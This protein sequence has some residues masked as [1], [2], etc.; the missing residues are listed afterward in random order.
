VGEKLY[1]YKSS[2][3]QLLQAMV[4]ATNAAS[5]AVQEVEDTGLILPPIPSSDDYEND[6]AVRF[7]RSMK[8][9]TPRDHDHVTTWAES[10]GIRLLT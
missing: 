4:K 3:P 1:K 7:K 9:A 10:C 5:S 8:E 6:P 2:L